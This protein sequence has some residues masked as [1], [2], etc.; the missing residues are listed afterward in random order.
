MDTLV[1]A[2]VRPMTVRRSRQRTCAG[3]A[4][5]AGHPERDASAT[6]IRAPAPN[7]RVTR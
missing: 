5:D 4:V 6:V 7:L 3:F 2:L 1:A